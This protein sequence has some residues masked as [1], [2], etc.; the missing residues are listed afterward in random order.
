MPDVAM[1]HNPECP[2]RQSCYR[3]AE[4]GTVPVER[5]QS[6]MSFQPRKA[7]GKCWAYIPVYDDDWHCSGGKP[8]LAIKGSD[9]KV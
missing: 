4:S 6:Y 3:H 9:K 1:C 8:L 7:D 2:S 5:R